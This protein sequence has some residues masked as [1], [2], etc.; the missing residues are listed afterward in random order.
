MTPI[1]KHALDQLQAVREPIL[2]ALHQLQQARDAFDRLETA[3][4]LARL[5]R[6]LNNALC[7]CLAARAAAGK[8]VEA[9]QLEDADCARTTP[10]P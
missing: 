6:A 2:N 7:H 10:T 3:Q 4:Y 1:L 9:A 8:L 5:D